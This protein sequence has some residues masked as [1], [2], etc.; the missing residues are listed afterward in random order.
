MWL[1]V[2]FGHTLCI[3][4]PETYFD[5]MPSIYVAVTKCQKH[6]TWRRGHL[7]Y[8]YTKYIA[9]L[10]TICCCSL[11]SR[12]SSMRIG[13]VLRQSAMDCIRKLIL[14]GRHW[15]WCLVCSPYTVRFETTWCPWTTKH[16]LCGILTLIYTAT[17][18]CLEKKITSTMTRYRSYR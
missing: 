17:K 10:D 2:G 3:D 11:R 15:E 9:F 12:E 16:I 13:H 8:R 4:F 7:V 6:I 5:A 14:Y 18:R 1:Y